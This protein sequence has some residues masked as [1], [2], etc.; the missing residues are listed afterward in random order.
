MIAAISPIAI[1][2]PIAVPIIGIAC[3]AGIMLSTNSAFI[4]QNTNSIDSRNA[5][6][7]CPNLC[8]G[9]VTSLCIIIASYAPIIT[10]NATDGPINRIGTV[11]SA[12]LFTSFYNVKRDQTNL[13][14]YASLC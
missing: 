6:V 12:N 9:T 14:V 4:V 11:G 8:V 1:C 7:I 2:S 13:F 5:C 10:P 3:S